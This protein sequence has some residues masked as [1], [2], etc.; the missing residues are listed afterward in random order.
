MLCCQKN[1]FPLSVSTLVI[2]VDDGIVNHY[3][4][5]YAYSFWFKICLF[6]HTYQ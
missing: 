3:R 6:A 5:Q 2:S 1:R 4:I